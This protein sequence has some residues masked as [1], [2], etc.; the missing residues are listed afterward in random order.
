MKNRAFTLMELLIVVT[1]IGILAAFAIPNY[2]QSVLKAHERDIIVQLSS[3]HAANLIYRAQNDDE[4]LIGNDLDIDAINT[5]LGIGIVANEV[6]YSYTSNDGQTYTCTA[7][8]NGDFD[9]TITE[10]VLSATNPSCS[11]GAGT[12]PTR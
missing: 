2:S 5:A 7:D 1:I 6:D 4:Y 12:C 11:S 8:Y 3:I 9:L 10:A